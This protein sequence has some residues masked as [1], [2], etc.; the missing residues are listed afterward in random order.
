MRDHPLWGDP[1][2]L[3]EEAPTVSIWLSG[4]DVSS[5]MTVAGPHRIHTGFLGFAGPSAPFR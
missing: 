3:V 2:Q 5:L 1:P 4:L